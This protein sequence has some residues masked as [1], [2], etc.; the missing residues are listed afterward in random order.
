MVDLRTRGHGAALETIVRYIRGR[1]LHA[2]LLT[3]PASVGKTT[4]A[5][6][7]AAG[8]LCTAA[9]PADRPCGACRA[10]RHVRSRSH[11]DLHWLEPDGPGGQI[12]IGKRENDPRRGVRDVV[13][14]LALA[15]LEGRV[16]VAIVERADRMNEEAQNAF[17]KTLE[18]PP[19][20]SVIVLCADAPDRLLPTIRS[21]C[22]ALRLGRV[23]TRTIEALLVERDLAEPPLARR[24]ARI[25]DGRPGR[26][27]AYALAPAALA[28]RDETARVLLDL[29]AV[30]A[31]ARL[32]ALRGLVGVALEA[33]PALGDPA[34]TEPA[35]R[36]GAESEPRS[37][38][39]IPGPERPA[40]AGAAEG[41]PRSDA[42]GAEAIEPE[43]E[44]ARR[45]R[46]T[47]A[48]R[49]AAARWVVECWR[50]LARDLLLVDLGQ[51]RLV[52]DVALLDELAAAAGRLRRPDLVRFLDR[53][54]AAEAA[55]EANAFPELVLDVLA[56]AWP[57]T[58]VAA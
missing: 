41:E 50:D 13:E 57:R 22:A 24:L 14:E 4:L 49:R 17:L 39:A 37:P 10:C 58:S 45:G 46:P 35:G 5:L 32:A 52:R 20:D 9:D 29:L 38:D 1:P 8:L 21:R 2:L 31:G 18:E 26:A 51:A 28:A 19:P 33:L 56:L 36:H 23:A 43:D 30:D 3:G 48:Q 11:P 55:L 40:E 16:R 42:D 25:A 7:L 44:T 54:L 47:A 53:S 27:V 12:V 6:D 15:P 34:E